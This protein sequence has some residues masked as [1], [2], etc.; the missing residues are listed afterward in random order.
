LLLEVGVQLVLSEHVVETEADVL[1]ADHA[2]GVV[3]GADERRGA[4]VVVAEEEADAVDADDSPGGG[5]G[6][7]LRVG[8]VAVVHLHAGR[9]R[10]R[11]DDW[12]GGEL[13]EVE[14]RPRGAVR[15]VDEHP[16]VVQ[17]T[18]QVAA[19]RGETDLGVVVAA[20]SGA[21]PQVVGDQD[22]AYAELP[23]GCEQRELA[24]ER[25]RSLEI[26]RDRKPAAAVR[27]M[28]VGDGR[29]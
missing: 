25:L 29:C 2:H 26:E 5:T 20:P 3:D 11:E 17:L 7:H 21:V 16:E 28:D 19:V 1:G 10:M 24:V 15:R 9:N 4:R 6:S 23:E 12:R 27:L 14:R 8:D 13:E 18:H 22:R